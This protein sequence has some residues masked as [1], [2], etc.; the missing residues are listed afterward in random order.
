MSIH[1]EHI[2]GDSIFVNGTNNGNIIQ[3]KDKEKL[4]KYYNEILKNI[5][6]FKIKEDEKENVR[7]KIHN[8]LEEVDKFNSDISI[9]RKLTQQAFQIMG[10][11][12]N[13]SLN[14]IVLK[15]KEI[16]NI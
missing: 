14:G 12:D 7:N 15:I 9:A 4:S 1:I 8:A 13:S 2:A 11:V 6:N 10:Y 3:I 16:L 5:D